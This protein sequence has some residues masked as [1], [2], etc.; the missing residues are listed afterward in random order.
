[1]DQVKGYPVAL[2]KEWDRY[3][4]L[5]NPDAKKFTYGESNQKKIYIWKIQ[6]KG[7]NRK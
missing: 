7:G 5:L 1:M 6:P 2:L 4:I 3:R